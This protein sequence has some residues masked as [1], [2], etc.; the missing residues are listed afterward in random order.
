MIIS[1]LFEDSMIGK[2]GAQSADVPCL[3]RLVQPITFQSS[4]ATR[5]IIKTL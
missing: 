2:T 1:V 3:A 5:F 4:T